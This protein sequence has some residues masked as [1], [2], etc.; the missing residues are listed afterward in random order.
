MNNHWGSL[1][2]FLLLVIG[3]SFFAAQFTPGEWYAG[4]VKPAWNPPNWLFAPVWSLLYVMIAV[5]GWQVWMSDHSRRALA[6]VLWS[7][8]LVLNAA[9][10]WLFFGLERTG[11][12]M[13]ELAALLVLVIVTAAVFRDIRRSA[14]ILLLPYIAWLG[15][16]LSLNV[17]IWRLNGG[18]LNTL[19]GN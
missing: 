9:W 19:L 2:I 11:V 10:S 17:A 7:A 8:Q 12:A 5:A 15:Y 13:F 4:L 1:I 14:S 16:A 18:G 6:L 3:V